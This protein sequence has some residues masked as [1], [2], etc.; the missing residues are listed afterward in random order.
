MVILS[1]FTDHTG[2]L[3]SSVIVNMILIFS[4]PNYIIPFVGAIV[5]TAII[6]PLSFL[7]WFRPGYKAFR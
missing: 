4:D 7:F 3:A 2:L 1:Y 6:V 5:Y